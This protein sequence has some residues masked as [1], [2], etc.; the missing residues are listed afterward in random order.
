VDGVHLATAGADL[1]GL[2]ET[3]V[4]VPVALV[5]L[6]VAAGVVNVVN[7][8]VAWCGPTMSSD[9]APRAM[10]P[11]V[12]TRTNVIVHLVQCLLACSILAVGEVL[13]GGNNL[14]VEGLRVHSMALVKF[15][16]DAVRW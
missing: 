10:F 4:D 8:E 2:G 15:N 3:L 1:L 9:S 14:R 6:V 5:H 13:A 12:K 7:V 11:M 16:G